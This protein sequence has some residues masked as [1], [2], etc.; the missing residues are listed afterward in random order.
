MLLY[1]LETI[2]KLAHPFAPFVTEAIWQNLAH[3]QGNLITAAW[4][5][6]GNSYTKEAKQFEQIKNIVAETRVLSRELSLIKPKLLYRSAEFKSIEPIVLR[7]AGAAS[8]EQTEKGRGLALTTTSLDV[9]IDAES[10][11]IGKY[12][13]KLQADKTDKERYIKAQTDL[14]ANSQFMASAPEQVKQ[15]KQDSKAE[16]ELLLSK[17]DAQIQAIQK[18]QV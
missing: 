1:G 6:P 17:L 12:L 4:P 13:A 2:L 14:L 7:L 9:W 11:V 5:E 10:D 8:S 16:A 3:K 15:Q 18:S